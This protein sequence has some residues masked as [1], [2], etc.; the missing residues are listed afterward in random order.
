MKLKEVLIKINLSV[1][2][3]KYSMK[4][5]RNREENKREIILNSL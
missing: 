2:G 4:K 1:V 3:K 5:N